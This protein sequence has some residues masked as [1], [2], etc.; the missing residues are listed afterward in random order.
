MG[1]KKVK[2]LKV[3]TKQIDKD[4]NKAYKKDLGG[5]NLNKENEKV[6]NEEILNEK[7]K[8]ETLNNEDNNVS[9]EELNSQTIDL[10]EKIEEKVKKSEQEILK[11][12]NEKLKDLLARKSAELDNFIKRT[13]KEKNDL[14]EYA[15]ESLLK[16]F[17][18]L[19]DDFK[20]ALD[21]AKN[22]K[23]YDS[24][25]KGIEMIYE[26]T[27]KTFKDTGVK[28]IEINPGD[29]FDVNL[30]EALMQMPSDKFDEGKIV[31]IAE[32]GYMLKDKVL[33]HAKVIT[34]SGNQNN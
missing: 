11:M 34:S 22:S 17:L 27:L 18:P 21:A 14:I 32:D 3:K 15:N 13:V 8:E 29:D 26:K 20:K 12:E 33:R 19:L 9:K 31:Q 10:D 1:D 6:T 2:P 30:H 28:K 7:L 24:L 4:L 5:D 25:L 16:R 23:D